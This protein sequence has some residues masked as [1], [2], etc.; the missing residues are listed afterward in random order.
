MR[1]SNTLWMLAI[2]TAIF[3]LIFL[4]LVLGS[5]S[6]PLQS[7]W[8]IIWNSGNELLHGRILSGNLDYHRH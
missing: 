1:H 5:V 4:N 3:V 2:V 8:H 7:V 6:I